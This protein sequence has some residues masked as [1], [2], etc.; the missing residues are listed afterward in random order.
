MN[1]YSY[2]LGTT[3]CLAIRIMDVYCVRQRRSTYG[4]RATSGPLAGKQKIFVILIKMTCRKLSHRKIASGN[5]LSHL[6]QRFANRLYLYVW[7]A[8]FVRS[9]GRRYSG[10]CYGPLAP[11]FDIGIFFNTTAMAHHSA[12]IL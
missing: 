11:R 4:P 10:K 9:V 5:L 3:L 8:M 12:F 1:N 2:D 7:P 6:L